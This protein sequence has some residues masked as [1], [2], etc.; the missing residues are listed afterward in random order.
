VARTIHIARRA[1]TILAFAT[2]AVAA[3]AALAA[4]PACAP[5]PTVT[6]ALAPLELSDPPEKPERFYPPAARQAAISGHATIE[7]NAVSGALAEC[8]VDD[9][10]PSDQGFGAAAL[11][12]A[13][14]LIVR[15]PPVAE[16]VRLDVDYDVRPPA[17]GCP[18][19]S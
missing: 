16:I 12:L 17:A 11:K 3:P 2:T 14:T 1:A 5:R 13:K 10:T 15:T 18:G 6:V 19:R 4:R 7:C 9:E 8:A